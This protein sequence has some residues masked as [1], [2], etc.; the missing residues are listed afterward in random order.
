MTVAGDNGL[1]HVI[2]SGSDRRA[3]VQDVRAGVPVAPVPFAVM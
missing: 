1:G 3:I 2:A